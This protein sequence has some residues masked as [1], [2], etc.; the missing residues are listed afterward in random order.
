MAPNWKEIMF[1]CLYNHRKSL[2]STGHLLTIPKLKEP[3]LKIKI[4]F[5]EHDNLEL[6][7]GWPSSILCCQS[8][9]LHRK[10][11]KKSI[12]SVMK[13]QQSSMFCRRAGSGGWGG[14]RNPK[15]LDQVLNCLDLATVSQFIFWI[16]R[17]L[18]YAKTAFFFGFKSYLWNTA[19]DF[20][21]CLPIEITVKGIKSS[22]QT[23][24][25]IHDSAIERISNILSKA[26][27]SAQCP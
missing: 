11:E 18:V 6:T 1:C 4:N 10:P 16:S 12:S 2:I 23:E 14:H 13:P 21:C 26:K 22:E 20:Q 5:D 15:L 3:L 24:I 7:F 19:V 8:K 17:P 27:T 9:C 25:K